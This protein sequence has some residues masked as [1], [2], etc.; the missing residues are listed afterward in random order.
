M[1]LTLILTGCSATTTSPNALAPVVEAESPTSAPTP[2]A[3]PGDTNEDGKLSEFEKQVVADTALRS[4]TLL[5]GSTVDVAP[6][7]PLPAAVVAAI[8]EQASPIAESF[9]F[10][11][12]DAVT[13]PMEAMRENVD[14]QAESVGKGIVFVAQGIS[15]DGS[16]PISVWVMVASKI[17]VSPVKPD[18]DFNVV[19]A[20]SQTWAASRNYE[21]ITIQ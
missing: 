20:G 12:G 13:P 3:I 8:Q 18:T 10:A 7:Q 5:D 16:G 11:E 17:D 2:K 14:A 9:R 19:L 15:D 21:V 6:A 4:Y 1:L